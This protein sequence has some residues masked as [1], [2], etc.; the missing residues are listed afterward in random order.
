MENPDSIRDFW[1]G[2]NPD[3]VI[4][5]QQHSK[6]W[7]SKNPDTDQEIRNRFESHVQ[8]TADHA[9]AAWTES[10]RGLLALVLLTDQF[11]RNMYRHTPKAFQFDAMAQDWC[12]TGLARGMDQLLRPIERVF[13]YL[14]LEH[15]E[16]LAHQEQ[17]VRLY[18]RL[19]QEV[20]VEQ[21][22]TFRRFLMFALRHRRI[23]ER[24][25]RF[26]HRNEVLG[27]PSTPEEA[28]FLQEPGSSF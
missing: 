23:I 4:V 11:T 24:F 9:L 10:P 26:P 6:L 14:P 1:F 7:W 19:Y 15:S 25:G 27:R 5:A 12:Q 20:P 21:M 17:S 22:D 28:L 8:K 3:D 16:S 13:F 2:S 18:T